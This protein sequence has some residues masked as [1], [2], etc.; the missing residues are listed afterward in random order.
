MK[1]RDL[2]NIYTHI[3]CGGIRRLS[4]DR[5][6]DCGLLQLQLARLNGSLC[7]LTF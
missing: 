1:R 5:S 2:I 7:L 3:K 6:A 4:T